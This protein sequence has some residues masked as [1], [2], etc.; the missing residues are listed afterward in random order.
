MQCLQSVWF[1]LRNKY[2]QERNKK[3]NYLAT[4]FFEATEQ[5]KESQIHLKLGKDTSYEV[6]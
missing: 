1:Y 5:R 3:L 2:P 6:K 4:C